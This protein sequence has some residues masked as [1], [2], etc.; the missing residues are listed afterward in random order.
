MVSRDTR[1]A[2]ADPTEPA[3][4]AL[5]VDTDGALTWQLGSAVTDSADR[6][7]FAWERSASASDALERMRRG[8]V[9]VVLLPIGGTSPGLVPLVK[10]RADAPDVPVIVLCA[11]ADEPL[12]VKAVQLG[13]ADYLVWERLYGTIVAR[14]L[15]HA[16]ETERVRAVLTRQRAEW[17][18]SLGAGSGSVPAALRNAFPVAFEA[19]VEEYGDILDAAV[20]GVLLRRPP[21]AEQRLQSVAAEVAQLRAGP[22]DVVDLHATAMKKREAEQGAQRMKLYAMEGRLRL[23]ELMGYLVT[24]YRDR[25]IADTRPTR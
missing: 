6:E 19:L 20:E 18:P 15:R 12:A 8:E 13:A 1:P 17:P 24:Y 23:L 21:P 16:V 3:L 11:A 14:S 2:A 4:R 5:V 9:D 10:L 22:R 25:W 7:R